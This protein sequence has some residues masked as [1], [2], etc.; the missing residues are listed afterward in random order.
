MISPFVQVP[1]KVGPRVLTPAVLAVKRTPSLR[2]QRSNL[3]DGPRTWGGDSERRS[4]RILPCGGRGRWCDRGRWSWRLLL[5]SLINEP[6]CRNRQAPAAPANSFWPIGIEGWFRG[7]CKKRSRLSHGAGTNE[8]SRKMCRR[9]ARKCPGYL[10]RRG[11]ID[12]RSTLPRSNNRPS[13]DGG[14]GR[15]PRG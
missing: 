15:L 3:A 6:D 9:V 14:L 11:A 10:L 12:D 7:V 2:A 4:G 1:S 8:S 13:V 5:K